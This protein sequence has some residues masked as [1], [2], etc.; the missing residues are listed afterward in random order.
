MGSKP[1]AEASLRR[2]AVEVLL[3]C[4]AACPGSA[5]KV[6]GFPEAFLTLCMT[7][8]A[9]APGDEAGA[10]REWAGKMV[11][12]YVGTSGWCCHHAWCVCLD[13]PAGLIAVLPSFLTCPGST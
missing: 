10:L 1:D 13:K 9:E 4:C 2:Q 6:A 7:L 3:T 12:A 11:R 5:R 8:C